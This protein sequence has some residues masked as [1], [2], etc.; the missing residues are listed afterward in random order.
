MTL[1]LG[2]FKM[3]AQTVVN[4]AVT[5]FENVTIAPHFGYSTYIY[6]KIGHFIGQNQIH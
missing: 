3:N 2:S 1:Y 4:V 5:N 6:T